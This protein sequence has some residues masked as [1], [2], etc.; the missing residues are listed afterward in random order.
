MIYE[1]GGK[2]EGCNLQEQVN[3]VEFSLVSSNIVQKTFK[4]SFLLGS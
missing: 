1:M 3:S 4:N 2:A